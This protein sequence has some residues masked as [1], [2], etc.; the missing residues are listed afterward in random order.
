MRYASAARLDLALERRSVCLSIS[1]LLKECAF[2]WDIWL[3]PQGRH[4]DATAGYAA[5]LGR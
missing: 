1:L 2:A 5:M 3:R 4:S